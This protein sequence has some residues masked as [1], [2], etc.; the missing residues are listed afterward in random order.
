MVILLYELF[1][2][3]NSTGALTVQLLGFPVAFTILDILGAK[4]SIIVPFIIEIAGGD[5]GNGL[6]LGGLM[7]LTFEAFEKQLI[8]KALQIVILV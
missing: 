7:L 8:I 5:G 4:R 1:N 2:E 3:L 6:G